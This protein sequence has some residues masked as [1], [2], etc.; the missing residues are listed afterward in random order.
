[1]YGLG[2]LF[3]FD[4]FTEEQIP[5]A[6][7]DYVPPNWMYQMLVGAWIQRKVLI[8]EDV[9]SG[10]DIPLVT[11]KRHLRDSLEFKIFDN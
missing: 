7:L 10:I 5:I 1:M 3:G 6:R 11:L 2:Y 9:L 4:V 8:G